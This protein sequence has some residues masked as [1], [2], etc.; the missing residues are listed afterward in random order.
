MHHPYIYQK[1]CRRLTAVAATVSPPRHIGG[2]QTIAAAAA[3]SLSSLSSPSAEWR[4]VDMPIEFVFHIVYIF[5]DFIFCYISF[6]I[7]STL[8]L[9][10][11]P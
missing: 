4:I 10:K 5:L 11:H 3:A 9:K 8:C 7:C 2:R 1:K 6:S